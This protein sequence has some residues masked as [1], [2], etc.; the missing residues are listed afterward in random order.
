M[1]CRKTTAST[2]SS[3]S[4][5]RPRWKLRFGRAVARAGVLE[6]LGVR[7]DADH[8][9]GALGEQIRAVTLAA[10]EVDHAQPRAAL[11]DPLVD[12]DVAPVPVVLLGDVGEGAL[13]GQL[14]R[15]DTLGLVLLEVGPFGSLIAGKLGARGLLRRVRLGRHR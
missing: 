12:G 1:V 11:G 8:L 7:V 6:G 15:R 13:A 3:N 14:E 5:T 4:S 10:G 2:A 9:G